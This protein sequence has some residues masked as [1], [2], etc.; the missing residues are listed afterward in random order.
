MTVQLDF[1]TQ[2]DPIIDKVT[3]SLSSRMVQFKRNHMNCT[4]HAIYDDRAKFL[5]TPVQ[6]VACSSIKTALVEYF[7]QT[8]SGGEIKPRHH[9]VH[10][11]FWIQPQFW[12]TKEIL[13]ELDLYKF[14]VV[15]DPL[16]R[17][18]S[19][20]RNRVHDYKDLLSPKNAQSM[21]DLP[22]HPSI[23]EFALHLKEYC[24]ANQAIHWHFRPQAD[25]IGDAGVYNKIYDLSELEKAYDDLYRE[26]GVQL[27]F[28]KRNQ[29]QSKISISMS[30]QAIKAVKTF[31]EKDYDAFGNVF[32]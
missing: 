2:R 11:F 27:N 24:A 31:F 13:C 20:Y 7:C 30:E 8:Y 22:S 26:C 1:R 18:V 14:C 9:F 32:R 3:R 5:Y 19:G 15:R 23:D 4:I 28:H 29:S 6:K 17:F 10:K 25:V 12:M 21:P 16:S